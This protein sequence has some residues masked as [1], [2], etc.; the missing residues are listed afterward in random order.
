MYLED[1]GGYLK[2]LRASGTCV[3]DKSLMPQKIVVDRI[4]NNETYMIKSLFAYTG[5]INQELSHNNRPLSQPSDLGCLLKEQVT[6]RN[7]AIT[8]L[9]K[10][11]NLSRKTIYKLFAGQGNSTS[12]INLLHL[13]DIQL[14]LNKKE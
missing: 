5:A 3:F 13:L 8:Q 4:E 12:Y 9:Q 6:S 11:L 14:E 10:D 2:N 7:L 1:I